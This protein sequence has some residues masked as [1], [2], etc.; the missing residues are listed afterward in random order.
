M[1]EFMIIDELGRVWYGVY[2]Y[3]RITS[4]KP[5]TSLDEL[6]VKCSAKRIKY[7]YIPIKIQKPD[8]IKKDAYWQ[9]PKAL[10]NKIEELV[11]A[12]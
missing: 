3:K 8:G 5:D 11:N 1:K 2:E 4:R 6:M 10:Y 7:L 12:N 9:M